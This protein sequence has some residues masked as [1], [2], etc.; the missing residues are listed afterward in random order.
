EEAPRDALERVPDLVRDA[1]DHLAERRE[2]AL[3]LD[4]G[5]RLLELAREARLLG[6]VADE[7]LDRVP[8]AD[9]ERRSERRDVDPLAVGAPRAAHR[10][11]VAPAVILGPAR[12]HRGVLLLV[13]DAL[14]GR[15]DE[16][17]RA[18]DAVDAGERL[19]RED[20]AP[21]ADERDPERRALDEER[22]ARLAL[23]ERAGERR[24]LGRAA[25]DRL[26]LARVAVLEEVGG[27]A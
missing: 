7:E 2:P 23:A 25:D 11:G 4:L 6:H 13:V 9:L 17:L 10:V 14:D 18:R 26:E 21:V 1:R 16:R 27:R 22:V 8:P 5:P 12:A 20:V 3:L 19:V 24:L 15:A